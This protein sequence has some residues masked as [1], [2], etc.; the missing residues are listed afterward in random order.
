[1]HDR[2]AL[3]AFA[4]SSC[5]HLRRAS[6]SRALVV[7]GTG[8]C[9]RSRATAR[10]GF[11]HV[12]GESKRG[13]TGRAPAST[14]VRRACAGPNSASPRC[15]CTLCN[16]G[17]R[18]PRRW[19]PHLVG[20]PYYGDGRLVRNLSHQRRP[21]TGPPSERHLPTACSGFAGHHALWTVFYR[22][23]LGPPQKCGNS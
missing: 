16:G 7:C 21:R 8:V 4:V 12:C 10:G 2:T 11:A 22:P 15:D 5:F 3:P 14:V 20:W 6:Q 17:A 23:Q 18:R 9:I 13:P 19:R 1:M